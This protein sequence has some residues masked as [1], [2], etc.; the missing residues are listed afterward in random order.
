MNSGD[1]PCVAWQIVDGKCRAVRRRWFDDRF[2]STGLGRSA[3]G[4]D[5]MDVE[6]V[7]DACAGF[8]DSEACARADDSHVRCCTT[9][10]HACDVHT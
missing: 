2:G 8:K 7:V 6:K 10:K 1:N 3:I 9:S 4:D 5:P